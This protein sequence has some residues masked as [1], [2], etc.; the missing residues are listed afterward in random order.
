MIPPER[1]Q[2]TQRDLLAVGLVPIPEENGRSGSIPRAITS[3]NSGRSNH[4]LLTVK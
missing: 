2:E 1:K 4:P 3:N